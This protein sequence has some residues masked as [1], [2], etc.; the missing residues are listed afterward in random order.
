MRIWAVTAI[1]VAVI[2]GCSPARSPRSLKHDDLVAVVPPNLAADTTATWSA[3]RLTLVELPELPDA[4]ADSYVDPF[5]L[6]TEYEGPA[7]LLA[8]DELR[9]TLEAFIKATTRPPTPGELGDDSAYAD[10][11]RKLATAQIL[12]ARLDLEDRQFSAAGEQLAAA[13]ASTGEA[14]ETCRSMVWQDVLP[15]RLMVLDAVRQFASL[16]DVPQEVV[17]L[18]RRGAKSVNVRGSLEN[19]IRSSFVTDPLE[20]IEAV[21]RAESPV[22]QVAMILSRLEDV[23][24]YEDFL[25]ESLRGADDP[26]DP[27]ATVAL[28]GDLTNKLLVVVRSPWP[29]VA[30]ALRRRDQMVESLW[31]ANPFQV[32]PDKL[33]A[34]KAKATIRN[35]KNALG[36]LVAYEAVLG[37]SG[38]LESAIVGDVQESATQIGLAIRTGVSIKDLP[39]DVATDPLSGKRY[40]FDTKLRMIRSPFEPTE[41][42]MPGLFVLGLIDPGVP[43]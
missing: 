26:F 2:A 4:A 34:A 32:A 13:C 28:A 17:N 15:S 8:R 24:P 38:M 40:I 3:T 41:G 12:T 33:D 27:V 30:S 25:E 29:E 36:V 10:Q 23:K 31:S 6:P 5:R 35:Q 43:Y 7:G 21:G 20:R 19:A 42:T 39:A 11:V 22:R 16:P 14:L 18:L 37:Q 1:V 9:R